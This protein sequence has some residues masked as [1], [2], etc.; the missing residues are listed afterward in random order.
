M[1]KVSIIVPIYNSELYLDKCIQS[2]INQ[3]LEDIEIILIDDCS[4]D[5]SKNK[6]EEYYN[7]YKNKIVPIYLSKNQ[8]QGA[9]RNKGIEVATG[10]YIL[11]DAQNI[12]I[13]RVK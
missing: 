1:A 11:F 2:L 8:K 3:T 5:N 6:I 7:L 12:Q 4:T 10:E 13:I 9:A